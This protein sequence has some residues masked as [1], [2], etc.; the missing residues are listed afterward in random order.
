[1]ALVRGSNYS[2]HWAGIPSTHS[3]P[4]YRG[5][6]PDKVGLI[7]IRRSEDQKEKGKL[8]ETRRKK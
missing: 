8:T 2:D 5:G 7:K 3:E 1:M 6:E 4:Y